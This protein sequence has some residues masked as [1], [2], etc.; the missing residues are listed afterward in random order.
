VAT[1]EYECAEHGRFESQLRADKIPCPID[2]HGRWAR[3]I[4]AWRNASVLQA[5]F[6]PAFG[7]EI[8]SR[9]QAAELAKRASQDQSE[10]LG[11]TVNYELTD[12]F[13]HEAAGIDRAEAK[14]HAARTVE[15]S[16]RPVGA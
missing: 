4:F 2:D 9:T 6:N 14:E 11:M 12:I 10:R 7:C 15:A 8:S 13:D 1:F 5:H 16:G 3:R